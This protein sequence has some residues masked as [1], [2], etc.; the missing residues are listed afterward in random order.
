MSLQALVHKR[1]ALVGATV[2]ALT[3]GALAFAPATA[4][5]APAP[6]HPVTVQSGS[7]SWGLKASFRGYITGFAGGSVTATAPATDPGTAGGV[8]TFPN[9]SGTFST[10]KS[11]TF[12]TQGS[13]NYTGHEGQLD[14]TISQPRLVVTPA[15]ATLVVD[16]VDSDDTAYDD[17]EL[18]SVDLAGHVSAEGDTLTVDDAPVTLL[19][20]GEAVFAYNGSPMYQAGAELAPLDATISTSTPTIS[21]SKTEFFADETATITVTGSGFDPAAAVGAQPPLSGQPS[22]YYVVFGKFAD[23]WRPSEDAGPSSRKNSSQKW[24]VPEPSYTT[25]LGF[26]GSTAAQAVL[27]NPDGTFTTQLTVSKAAVDAVATDPSLKNYG[28]YTYAG[29]GAKV[30]AAETYTPVTFV[31]PSVSVSKTEFFTDETATITVEGSGFNPATAVGAQPPLSGQPSGYYVVFGKFADTWRPSEDAG[32]SSRKNSS[33]KWAVPEPSYTTL[34]GFGGSTAAQAVLLNP[35]GTFTTQLTVSKAAVDA[36]ATDPSLKNY[37]IYTYA[38]GGAKVAAAETH[39]PVTF[40]KH[41]TTVSVEDVQVAFG[42]GGAVTATVTGVDSGDLVLEGLPGGD[43]TAAI[44]EGEAEFEVPDDLAVGS[45]PLTVSFAGDDDHNASSDTAT[46]TVTKTATGLTVAGPA[47]VAYGA[48]GTFVATAT[49]I[50]SGKELTVTGA[51]APQTIVVGDDGTATFVLPKTLA[52]GATTLTVAYAGDGTTQAASATVTVTVQKAATTPAPKVT[53]KVSAKKGGKVK[54]TLGSA[55]GT[56]P[57][58]K[59]TVTLKKGKKTKKVKGTLKNGVV[60]I[61]VPKLKKGKW[62]GTVVYAGSATHAPSTTT[63]KLKVK[64]K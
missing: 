46:L 45:Y 37:G 38:G 8:T 29:G 57:T 63:F 36:V 64:K 21:V 24:A 31:S 14:L 35:D 62:K 61:K 10:N 52:P 9:G 42:A 27:L 7:I 43:V 11:T 6:D 30:A 15:G 33:Q 39:T 32:P 44:D 59:V 13:V 28:I 55:D 58:G 16:A 25:L 53:K 18:A 49:G 54:V 50:A 2:A 17:L 34:L 5:A 48:G 12:A 20:S 4:H 60:V 51:G 23:T 22:G 1:R 26:G 19:A 41:D 40:V 47:S 3:A 56:A